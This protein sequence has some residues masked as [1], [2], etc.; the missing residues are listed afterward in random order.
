MALLKKKSDCSQILR[1]KVKGIVVFTANQYDDIPYALY[2]PKY[3]EAGQVGNI[4]KRNYIDDSREYEKY[5]NFVK[6]FNEANGK[7]YDV[8]D[9]AKH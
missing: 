3:H 1:G 5:F 9:Y 7:D 2:I 4:L 8:S 6:W